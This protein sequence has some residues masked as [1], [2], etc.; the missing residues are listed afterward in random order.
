MNGVGARSRPPVWWSNGK[1]AG[2]P[3][4]KVLEGSTARD[5][6]DAPGEVARPGKPGEAPVPG[7]YSLVGAGALDRPSAAALWIAYKKRWGMHRVHSICGKLKERLWDAAGNALR[8]IPVV[9]EDEIRLAQS[10]LQV[11]E[12]G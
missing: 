4:R 12:S 7:E 6:H 8:D 3:D 11:R 2:F 1:H 5:S 9:T 10:V